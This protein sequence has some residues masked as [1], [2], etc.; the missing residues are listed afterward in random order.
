[1]LP[2]KLGILEHQKYT[3]SNLAYHTIFSL[4]NYYTMYVLI[5]YAGSNSLYWILY[6]SHM[7]KKIWQRRERVIEIFPR[8][9]VLNLM[10]IRVKANVLSKNSIE[11]EKRN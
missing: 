4:N 8:S 11:T 2:T 9:Y 7:I 5:K 1:M 3:E 10:K 6:H